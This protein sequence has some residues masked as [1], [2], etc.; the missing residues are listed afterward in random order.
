MPGW[1]NTHGGELHF[2]EK[3]RGEWEKRD[4]RVSLEGKVGGRGLKLGYKVN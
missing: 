1:V 2:S 4:V 3:E